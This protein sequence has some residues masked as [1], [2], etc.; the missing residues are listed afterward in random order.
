MARNLRKQYV[1]HFLENKQT[2]TQKQKFTVDISETKAQHICHM[3]VGTSD[4]TK[5][6]KI[7]QI[8]IFITL[9]YQC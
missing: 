1:I 9:A 6:F 7:F 8:I 2:S 5:I 4:P 3:Y